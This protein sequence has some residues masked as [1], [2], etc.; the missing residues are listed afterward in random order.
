MVRT[1]GNVKCV[2]FPPVVI[3]AEW[4]YTS[5]YGGLVACG[6]FSTPCEACRGKGL[7]V[8]VL[9]HRSIHV[10]CDACEGSG[11]RTAATTPPGGE[12]WENVEK[13]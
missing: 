2:R 3:L 13:R 4:H 11:W 7:I 1:K 10:A 9:R 6:E 8:E 12:R 5:V